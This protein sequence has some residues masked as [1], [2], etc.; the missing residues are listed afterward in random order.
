LGGFGVR[1]PLVIGGS[2]LVSLAAESVSS[3]PRGVSPSPLIKKFDEPSWT[4]FAM[5]A[6]EFVRK[7]SERI[8]EYYFYSDEFAC[9][10]KW[11]TGANAELPYIK[12]IQRYYKSSATMWRRFLSLK[13]TTP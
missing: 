3:A 12:S 4:P 5:S 6:N 10:P 2:S 11:F 7:E 8:T 1:G 9:P 13:I